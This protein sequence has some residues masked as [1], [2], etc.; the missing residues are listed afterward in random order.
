MVAK[1]TLVEEKEPNN[2]FARAQPIAADKVLL[3]AIEKPKDVDV[4]RIALTA[5]QKL[6]AEVHAARQHSPLDS[7]VTLYDD[8]RHPLAT[9]DG[10]RGTRDARIEFSAPSQGTY[11]LSL[12]DAQDLGSELHVYRLALRVE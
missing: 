8:H 7:I 11:F 5:G 6:V 1:E 10:Q 2:G 9:N 4:F 12:I 3:G